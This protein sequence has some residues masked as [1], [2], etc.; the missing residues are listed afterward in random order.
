MRL[1]VLLSQ[2][3]LGTELV[4]CL[5]VLLAQLPLLLSL[6]VPPLLQVTQLLH[7]PRLLALQFTQLALEVLKLYVAV[8]LQ[9][10]PVIIV[11]TLQALHMSPPVPL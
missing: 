1:P 5:V 7:I 6:G 3:L 10:L 4:Q 11:G 8:I 9:Q 2:L